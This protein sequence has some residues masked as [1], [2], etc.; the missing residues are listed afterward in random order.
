MGNRNRRPR[1]TVTKAKEVRDSL[2][3]DITDHQR[4]VGMLPN[5]IATERFLDAEVMR[6]IEVDHEADLRRDLVAP[7]VGPRMRVALESPDV[8][9]FQRPG[10]RYIRGKNGTLLNVN[11]TL[12]EDPRGPLY[13]PGTTV[14][15]DDIP[16]EVLHATLRKMKAD[17]EWDKAIINIWLAEH[18]GDCSP[19]KPCGAAPS[20]MCMEHGMR[21]VNGVLNA[22]RA[23]LAFHPDEDPRKPQTP[24]IIT[25]G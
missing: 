21:K 16:A 18:D 24:K 17:P 4:N 14:G 2:V 8:R 20:Q 7:K 22:V 10:R 3:K 15:E 1:L 13:K 11:G 5:V 12:A 19:L 9:I 6:P 23:Y 25:S